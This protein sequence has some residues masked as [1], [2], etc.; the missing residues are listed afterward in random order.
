MMTRCATSHFGPVSP[1]NGRMSPASCKSSH[2]MY[3]GGSWLPLA[4]P[5]TTAVMQSPVGDCW[6]ERSSTSTLPPLITATAG[7]PTRLEVGG[8]EAQ[9][10][11]IVLEYG[12]QRDITLVPMRGRLRLPAIA[13]AGYHRLLIENREIVV[14]VAPSRCYTIE[15]AVP[16]ARLWGIAAQ[17]Y[18]LRHHERWRHRRRVRC[19]HVG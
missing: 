1:S 18:S 4:C 9:S 11:R 2:L 5:A 19:R 13:E 10:A 15:D 7:R 6:H 3:C 12:E 14:A 16:D 17:V 8:N